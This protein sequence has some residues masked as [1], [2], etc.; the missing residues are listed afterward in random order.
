MEENK[1]EIKKASIWLSN[2]K[3][4]TEQ[5]EQ[6][7]MMYF[8]VDVP[9]IMVKYNLELTTRIKALESAMQEFCDRRDRGELKSTYT[10][11]KFKQLLTKTK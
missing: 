9:K 5:G 3:Y 8:D 4:Q 2:Q 11:E 1:D 6:E 7:Y 10:Y